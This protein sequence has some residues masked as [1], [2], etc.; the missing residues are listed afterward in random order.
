MLFAKAYL[1]LQ[2]QRL[3]KEI[4]NVQ[5]DLQPRLDRRSLFGILGVV[6]RHDHLSGLCLCVQGPGSRTL[7]GLIGNDEILQHFGRFFIGDKFR[8]TDIGCFQKEIGNF[9]VLREESVSDGYSCGFMQPGIGLTSA[10]NSQPGE[11]IPSPIVRRGY[12][13]LMSY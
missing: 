9:R 2:V 8:K 10:R 11:D 7:R 3:S 5:S 12:L 13:S 4:R 6:Y 1:W